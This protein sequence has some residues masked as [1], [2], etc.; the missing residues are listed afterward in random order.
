MPFFLS[1]PPGCRQCCSNQRMPGL[2]L[3][4]FLLL[5]FLTRAGEQD[6][7]VDATGKVFSG[8]RE[9][10]RGPVCK[11]K[12]TGDALIIHPAYKAVHPAQGYAPHRSSCGRLCRQRRRVLAGRGNIPP[13][14]WMWVE[15]TF[16]CGHVLAANL[17]AHSSRYC[18]QAGSHLRE[19]K[20]CTESRPRETWLRRP[21]AIRSDV[22]AARSSALSVRMQET[23]SGKSIGEVCLSTHLPPHP[24]PLAQHPLSPQSRLA[25]TRCHKQHHHHAPHEV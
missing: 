19:A 1:L 25:K 7:S 12:E 11:R 24:S 2:G 22:R 6:L 8:I 5:A 23:P 18:I 15:I 13:Q 3:C 20:T 10:E 9:R 21:T 17:F 4:R 14:V 16:T